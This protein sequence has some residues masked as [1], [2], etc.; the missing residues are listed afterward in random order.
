[1]GRGKSG[2]VWVYEMNGKPGQ[3]WDPENPID[4]EKTKELQEV[5]L[6]ALVQAVSKK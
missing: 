4:I 1:M 5:I 6:D 2:R 3:V